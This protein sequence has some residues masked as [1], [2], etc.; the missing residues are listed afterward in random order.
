MNA[1]EVRDRAAT[2][3]ATNRAAWPGLLAA[4]LVGGIATMRPEE[5]FPATK[6]VDVHLIFADDA[7]LPASASPMMG[8]IETAFCGVAIEAGLRRASEYRSPEAVLGN[9]EIAYHLCSPNVVL[10]DPE[11]LL[12]RLRPAVT[13]GYAEPRWV[14]ARLEHER[15]G[16]RNALGLRPMMASQYGTSGEVNILGYAS[17]FLGATLDVAT[18][19]PPRAGGRVFVR[20]RER[21]AQLRRPDLLEAALGVLGVRDVDRDFVEVALAETT[22]AFDLAVA[23]RQRPHPFQ[24]KLHAHL[25][26]YF[27][28]SC[29]EMI[30]EGFHREALCW[31]TPFALACADVLL[32]DGPAHRRAK[33]AEQQ[34]AFLATLGFAG[35]ATCDAR[36]AEALVVHAEIFALA[37]AMADGAEGGLAA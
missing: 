9:P 4:H 34:T 18:L 13:R 7:P 32:A 11:G 6:D 26:P 17:T 14:R 25:R 37:E 31:I 16:H 36:V 24:H 15:Q 2:W 3:V 30:E 10:A 29:A 21:L 23:V 19:Q 22:E 27:V 20:L 5:P 8:I 35:P 12:A 33:V 1:G 28:D